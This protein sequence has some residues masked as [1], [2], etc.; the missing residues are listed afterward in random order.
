MSAPIFVTI[1]SIFFLKEKINFFLLISLTFGFAGILLVIQPGF[2]NFNVFFLLV[3]FGAL[4]ITFNT[5]LVNKY[6]TIV[7]SIGYFVYGGIFIHLFSFILF[8]LDPLF[9]D[10]YSLFLI[11]FA[12]AFINIA[13]LFMVYAL[14][15]SQKYYASIF[16][17]VYLQ[18]FWS[19]LIG[20]FIFD[21][22]LNKA[23]LIGAFF[24]ILSGIFS[25]PAQHRQLKQK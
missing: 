2:E 9:L 5:V 11:I 18:I 25:I 8:F 22:Y 17:L 10:F 1:F 4:L 21:E 14:Q 3:L 19:A 6:N 23:A 12:S 7:S 13:I 20:I 24:I 15:N 16:C